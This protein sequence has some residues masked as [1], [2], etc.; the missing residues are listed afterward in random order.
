[1]RLGQYC[2]KGSYRIRLKSLQIAQRAIVLVQGSVRRV[3]MPKGVIRLIAQ[4]VRE[5][6]NKEKM[7]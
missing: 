1:M 4:I 6:M 5:V 3:E 7:R 2:R